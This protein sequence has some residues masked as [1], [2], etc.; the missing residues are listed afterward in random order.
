ML[1]LRSWLEEY[2]DLSGYTNKELADIITT[3]SSEV[4]EVKVINDYFDGKIV[5]GQIK[6]V[7]LHPD[8]DR[9]RIFDVHIGEEKYVKIVSAAPNVEEDLLVPVALEGA[10]LPNGLTIVPRKMRGEESQGMCCGMSELMMETEPSAGLWELAPEFGRA[11]KPVKLGQSIC[12]AFPDFF[13]EEV[14]FDIKVLPNRIGVFGSYLGMALEIAFCLEN[15]GLLKRKASRILDPEIFLDDVRTQ[16]NF[17]PSNPDR[18]EVNFK[19]ETGYTKSFS[20]FDVKYVASNQYYLPHELQK[21]MYLTGINMIGGLA[22]VSNYLLYDVGQPTHFFSENKITTLSG[23]KS[24]NWEVKKLKIE[25]NFEGLGQLK[26][27][28]LAKDTTVL[29]DNKNH[30]LAIP[31]I[32]GALSSSLDDN[33]KQFIM[34]IANFSAEDVSRTSFALKYRSDGSKV[35]SG[36]V[37]QELLFITLLHFQELLGDGVYISPILFWSALTGRTESID[38]FLIQREC[39]RIPIDLEYLADRLDGREL[40]YW[41][42]IIE[43]KLQH[44]GNYENGVLITEAFYSNLENQQ[45]VL[46]ELIRVIG[47][48][49]LEPQPLSLSTANR[50]SKKYSKLLILKQIL[51]DFGFDEVITRPFVGENKLISKDQSAHVIK[52]YRSTEPYLRDNLMYPLIDVVSN[53]VKEGFKEPRIFEVNNVFTEVAGLI[54]ESKELE[55]ILISEDPYLVTSLTHEIWKKTSRKPIQEYKQIHDL[56]DKVG[57]GFW[58]ETNIEKDTWISIKQISNSVKKQFDLPLNKK[59]WS[60]NVILD[61][62]DYTVFPHKSYK[63]ESEYPEVRRSYSLQVDQKATWQ[64]IEKNLSLIEVDGIEIDITPVERAL[65]DGKEVLTIDIKFVSYSKT[66]KSEDIAGFE[67]LSKIALDKIGATLY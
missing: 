39:S 14:V 64:E 38:E 53:N 59:V 63:D 66:L 27:A 25:T 22:D 7:R 2:I 45:D 57:K 65:I 52:P 46:E 35:W 36:S 40:A 31:G 67:V 3:K 17:K 54:K 30:I 18:N 24:I 50:Q 13:P 51:V 1:F 6:N 21:R 10:K 47:F 43:Q 20:L 34:E 23:N 48:E 33:E 56:S 44:L 16:F 4:E 58:L 12:E 28:T 19:D 26:K 32:S 37:N 42:P 11:E 41:Q 8:A 9:L 29:V 15:K 62:W 5:V 61:H 49:N 60:V 55:A